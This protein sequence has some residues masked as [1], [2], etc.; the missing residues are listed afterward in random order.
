MATPCIQAAFEAREQLPPRI[1]RSTA[2]IIKARRARTPSCFLLL[3][4]GHAKKTHSFISIS[5]E[6]AS[7][8]FTVLFLNMCSAVFDMLECL[9]ES[10]EGKHGAVSKETNKW[11][12]VADTA[13]V[14][15][16]KYSLTDKANKGRNVIFF[17]ILLLA[18]KGLWSIP[19]PSPVKGEQ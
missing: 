16:Q 9:D 7:Y 14:A 2:H 18:S 4:P 5:Q 12:A 17:S 3:L 8:S 6:A 10:K 1:S 19:S 13:K 15:R 11:C